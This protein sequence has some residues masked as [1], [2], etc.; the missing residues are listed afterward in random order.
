[1]GWQLGTM[2]GVS[3]A[4]F[5]SCPPSEPICLSDSL[6]EDLATSSLDSIAQALTLLN[7]SANGVNPNPTSSTSSAS[8]VVANPHPYTASPTSSAQSSMSKDVSSVQRQIVMPTIR[9]SNTSTNTTPAAKPRP[10][11]TTTPLQKPFGQIGIKSA[12]AMPL[13]AQMKNPS[14]KSCDSSTPQLSVNAVNPKN[15]QQLSMLPSCT[16]PLLQKKATPSG[17]Q[18]QRFITPMQAT[19]TKSSQ[20]SSS[21]IIKL[22]HR[23]PLQTPPSGSVHRPSAQTTPGQARRSPAQI[24]PSGSSHHPATQATPPGPA[25]RSPVPTMPPTSAQSP[26]QAVPPAS[27]HRS[28]VSSPSPPCPTHHSTVTTSSSGHSNRSLAANPVSAH[29]SPASTL[30][31]SGSS[32]RPLVST[33]PS[34]SSNHPSVQTSPSSAYRPSV[35]TPPPNP[36]RRS[37]V[38]T[39]PSVSSPS[40][41]PPVLTPPTQYNPKNSGFKPPLCPA[42]VATPHTSSFQ[43]CNL[44]SSS[45][46]TNYGQR[47]R[48]VGGVNQSNK[49]SANCASAMGLPPLSES[50]LLNQVQKLSTCGFYFLHVTIH[51][52]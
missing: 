15:F 33:P 21:P 1:M 20:S 41:C 36:T 4:P 9:P 11:P 52:A 47:Q 45:V 48:V 19:I 40:S 30:T 25:H 14:E 26:A 2:P 10:P 32:H 18:Q 27:N 49:S 23:L 43:D 13:T 50:A 46:T 24:T 37:P 22:T 44:T 28:S 12:Q 3:P 39:P 35:P 7:N 17:H 5:T 51:P 38:A 8:P 16:S 34:P 6:D 31:L 29:R 42:P